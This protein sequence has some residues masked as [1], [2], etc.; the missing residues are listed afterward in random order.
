[1]IWRAA[2][3]LTWF[4]AAK[5]VGAAVGVA[6]GISLAICQSGMYFGFLRDTTIVLDAI[7]G[8]VWIVP[9]NQP[10]FDGF[11]KVDDQVFLRANNIDGVQAAIEVVWDDQAVRLPL[12]GGHDYV[13]ILGVDVG[14]EWPV[15]LKLSDPESLFAIREPGSVLVSARDLDKLELTGGASS[16]LE[17]GGRSANVVGTVDGVRLFS[18]ASFIMTDLDN[19]R[20]FLRLPERHVTYVACRIDP[21][22]NQ[23]AVIDE[24]RRRIPEHDVLPTAEFRRICSNYW[25][26]NS[27]IGPVILMSGV[28]G[29]IVGGVVAGF[30]VY[31]AV[32]QRLKTLACFKALGASNLELVG[33]LAV[34]VTVICGLGAL[35]AVGPTWAAVRYA[36]SANITMAVEAG[37]VVGCLAIAFLLV[38]I[39][40]WS[41]VRAVWRLDPAE[42]FR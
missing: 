16:S 41:S 19:A 24:L 3:R 38:A 13:Q 40:A 25:E 9:R 11:A 35:F 20:A 23:A 1:M 12:S 6:L 39:A 8:D 27:G 36:Q 5:V 30:M 18:T 33:M 14:D 2:I 26:T 42:A 34:Y 29:V 15:G 37:Q 22:A 28:L 7:G 10:T 31:L 21:G 4:D 17:I 32:H